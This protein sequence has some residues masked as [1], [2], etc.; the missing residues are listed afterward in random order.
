MLLC[1][2]RMT[3]YQKEKKFFTLMSETSGM[4]ISLHNVFTRSFVFLRIRKKDRIESAI[5]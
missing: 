3:W 1:H 2:L 5:A 4:F